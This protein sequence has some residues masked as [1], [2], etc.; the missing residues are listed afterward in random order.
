MKAL[1]F[2]ALLMLPV[3]AGA[4]V[5][6]A[7]TGTHPGQ[8][9]ANSLLPIKSKAELT[10]YLRDTPAGTSPLDKLSPWARRRFLAQL[11]FGQRGVTTINF[12]E[13]MAELTHPQIVQLFALFGAEQEKLAQGL[14]IGLT[15]TEQ[16]RIEREHIED[17]K[18]RGCAPEDCPESEIERRYDELILQE[19]PLSI[20][21][22]KRLALDRQR[23]GRLF[24]DYQVPGRLS[25]TSKPDLR[26]LVRAVNEVLRSP[27]AM[28]GTYIAQLRMD[29]TEMQRRGMTEDK[30]YAQL[31]ELLLSARQFAEA[32]A[33]L[34]QHPGLGESAMPTVRDSTANSSH[35][36]PSALVV[37]TQGSL[38]RESV[39]L[40]REVQIVALSGDGCHFC[41]E[42]AQAIETDAQLR[43]LFTHRAIWLASQ[44]DDF[45]YAKT[46]NRLFPDQPMHIAWQNSEWS[47]LGNDAWAALPAF[48]V[49]QN[50]KLTKKFLGWDG[51]K[52]FKQ[53]LREAGALH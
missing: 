23:Y 8:T 35:G 39:D 37:D 25:T 40:S 44:G 6:A 18:A 16:S 17:A 46:W 32:T 5:M 43:P 48:Y 22:A 53:S 41:D 10:H 34:H 4:A 11:E 13:P 31:Y 28:S 51:I 26:L 42:A 2:H 27:S 15:P 52:K 29:L 36:T 50:G 1:L 21:A 30:D 14:D 47:M 9:T 20:P 12:G 38:I 49:Y 24:A 3:A 45:A 19:P 7:P 33:L